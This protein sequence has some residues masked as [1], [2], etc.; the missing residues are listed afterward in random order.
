MTKEELRLAL[1][2]LKSAYVPVDLDEQREQ[3]ISA[4]EAELKEKSE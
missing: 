1:E 4:I 3:A 2:V